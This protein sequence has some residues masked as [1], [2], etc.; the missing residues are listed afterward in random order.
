MMSSLNSFNFTGNLGK[1]PELREIDGGKEVCNFPVAISR[2]GDK[3]PLWV[4]VA[5]WGAGAGP[6]SRYLSKGSQVAIHGQVEEIRTWESNGNHGA[7]LKVSTRDV[8]FIG[9]K[10][11]NQ[12]GDQP[13][14]P[15][16]DFTG[17]ASSPSKPAADDDIPF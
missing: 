4:D 3:A 1:D 2:Y 6:C 17:A 15:S 14:L 12:S 10:A 5:V 16:N 7:T 11:D 13:D 9:A 8:S